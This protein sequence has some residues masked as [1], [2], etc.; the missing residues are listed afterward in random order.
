MCSCLVPILHFGFL[1]YAKHAA[2]VKHLQIYIYSA[3]F[4]EPVLFATL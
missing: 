4:Y 2:R 1:K 3:V